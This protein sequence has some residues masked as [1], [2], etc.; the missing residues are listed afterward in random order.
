MPKP[1]SLDELIARKAAEFAGQIRHTAA[2][3]DKEEE[4]RIAVERQLGF[5]EGEAGV[6]LQGRHEFT[7]A[8]GRADSLYQRVLIEYKNPSSA[9]ARIGSSKDSPGCKKPV[10]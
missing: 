9:A 8:K 4:I 5:I 6:E 1:Q 2:M 3:A 7:V 10:K